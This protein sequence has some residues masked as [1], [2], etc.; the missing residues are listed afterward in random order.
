[1]NSP[2][3][4]I[5]GLIKYFRFS[6]DEILYEISWQNLMMFLATIPDYSTKEEDEIEPITTE[7]LFNMSNH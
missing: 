6:L 1:M 7:E 4:I 5:G 3:G 2:W